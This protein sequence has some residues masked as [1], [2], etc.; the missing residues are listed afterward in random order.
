[1]KYF[2]YLLNRLLH[3]KKVRSAIK[4]VLVLLVVLAI[5]IPTTLYLLPANSAEA[6]W[7]NDSWSYRQ[8]IPIDTHT[9]A[10]TNVYN[11][12]SVDTA[13]LT[14]DKLQADCDD[15]RFT[16]ENGELLPYQIISGCDSGTTVINVGFDTMPVAPFNIYMYYGNPSASAGSTTISHT[17]CGNGCAEGTFASEE[18]GQ[19]PVGYWKFDEGTQNTC[20]GGTNDFCNS[21]SAGTTIDANTST[22]A[23]PPTATSGYTDAGISGK[24]LVFDG[25]DDR[26]IVTTNLRTKLTLNS[27]TPQSLSISGWFKPLAGGNDLS[28]VVLLS[29]G[30]NIRIFY[31][32]ATTQ[33]C[34]QIK[35]GSN[36]TCT[37]TGSVV[38]GQ[39]YHVVGTYDNVGAL[40]SIYLNGVFKS[41]A[42][43]SDVDLSASGGDMYIG[44]AQA[45][46]K[47]FIDEVKVY[48]FSISAAQ[49]TSN[50]NS[51]G[52][53]EGAST[54]LGASSNQSAALSNGL[55]GYWKMDEASWTVDCSTESVTDSSGN[56]NN[57]S[58]CPTSTGPAGGAVGK[59]GN[60]AL[61][62][63]SDDYVDIDNSDSL[64]PSGDFT[65]S[66]WVKRTGAGTGTN[67]FFILKNAMYGFTYNNGVLQ[68][69][70]N[71][72]HNATSSTLTQDTWY[73]LTMVHTSTA[74]RLYI[75][76]ALDDSE[77]AGTPSLSDNGALVLGRLG[78]SDLFQ[79]VL[80]EVRVYNRALSGNEV[81]QL[82][83]FA[84]EPNGYWRLDEQTG[85]SAVDASGYGSTG[86]LTSVS[87]PPTSTSGWAN[88]KYG[89]SL[90]FDGS[91]D[92]VNVGGNAN[93][94]LTSGG[95]IAAWIYTRSMGESNGGRIVNKG[96]ST[97]AADGYSFQVGATNK[98]F[99]QINGTAGVGTS[100]DTL[101]LNAWNH[102]AWSFDG[103]NYKF[104]I[105]G[106]L[107]TT[108]A[109]TNLPPAVSG[110]VYIGNRAGAS[111]RTFDGL[112]DDVKIYPY[113]RSQGQIV[114]DMNASHPAPGSPVGS[115]FGHWK[116]D[117]G[118]ANTCSGGTNDLCNSGSIGNSIDGT[119][120]ATNPPTITQAGKF[121][122]ALTFD[123]TN[124]T[125]SIPDN[126][127]ID[128]N[129]N[130]D[131]TVS[132]WLKDGGGNANNDSILTKGG[133][134]YP[135]RFR[136]NEVDSLKFVRYDGS[137][138]A[139]PNGTKTINDGNWH[140]IAGVKRGSTLYLYIDGVQHLT[141]TDT[142]TA[143]TTNANAITLGS[144]SGAQF[145]AGT[146]DELRIFASGLT[147]DQIKLEYN[148]GASQVLGALSDKTGT[149]YES[150]TNANQEYCIPGDPTSCA[151]PVGRWD[152]EEGSG[153]S[154]QDTSDNS[155]TGTLTSSPSY[156]AGKVGKGLSFSGSNYVTVAD[157]TSLKP[158]QVTVSA[159]IYRTG[160]V[161][162][163]NGGGIAGKW[164][165]TGD[166]DGYLLWLD[167]DHTI[168]FPID[169]ATHLS[170]GVTA[171]LNTWYHVEGT[172]D[173][174]TAKIYIN[175]EYKAQQADSLTNTADP[176]EIGRYDDAANTYFPGKIDQVR[177]FDY[178]R[179]ASQVAWD[180]NKGAPFLH[181]KFDECQGTTLNDSSGNGNVG[182]INVDTL[183]NTTVGTCTSPT[184]G[185]GAWYD[186]VS[187]KRNYSLD[188]DGTDDEVVEASLSQTIT[189]PAPYSISVWFYADAISD[190]AI[191]NGGTDAPELRIAGGQL[192]AW[193]SNEDD[194]LY[195]NVAT[196]QWYHAVT[197]FDGTTGRLYINGTSSGTPFAPASPD[198]VLS[199]IDIGSRNANS[200]W[201]D[202]KIDDFRMY[203]YALT[204]LQVKSL[205]NDGAT[206]FGPTTGAP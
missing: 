123:G 63:G 10:E 169:G 38:E 12:I 115:A 50:F 131:F 194:V 134:T 26:A 71:S 159:W 164:S 132:F 146:L 82:Y 21:G 182:I 119:L 60:G 89:G 128:F 167:T 161:N 105:N 51:R 201:F 155:N 95:T 40:M 120:D 103:V 184:D 160:A 99:G 186:G 166:D 97:G 101:T 49:A 41:S 20:S 25:T 47:G 139:G 17:A 102:V 34:F 136:Y 168:K 113:A 88:G 187:G 114:E 197:T 127:A 19:A 36:S 7:F 126:D 130:Q 80:D 1:M 111:D 149:G 2:S 4:K 87:D 165:S 75:N 189:A 193:F 74:S 90:N 92:L 91:D 29:T 176:F 54:V 83:N 55:V 70:D 133:S 118:A 178:A 33:F 205:Y 141:A 37:G 122:K 69:Y 173:G 14:T 81:S 39:W 175:G 23:Q 9:A 151:A 53:N 177:V 62:D 180:Y 24:A 195:N 66:T 13:T 147:A 8:R 174:T 137:V 163:S 138:V 156:A 96:T 117:E 11:A 42:T 144:E 191:W 48:G 5:L 28:G 112:I 109:N 64:D 158:S 157:H 179:S 183:G 152:F 143:T 196:G 171:A 129:F 198:D 145:Y 68:Y 77:T 57:G 200:K 58:S 181:F 27:A 192:Q 107:L 110:D 142:T 31:R 170:S 154:A 162:G 148:R 116:F 172:F 73:H 59:F 79:G 22:L 204:A 188:F 61:F 32:P 98:I 43:P 85:T 202:G 121:G 206:R 190:N 104:Y 84:P 67:Q 124:D 203:N 185:T 153:T 6:A 72:Y 44:H 52:S 140:H 135:Y 16:K 15:L 94:Q 100:N 46:F 56:L 3:I 78:G 199:S 30:T 106:V 125:A 45:Y 108:S 93:L 86:T 35:A 150:K 76:G 18:K 65:L